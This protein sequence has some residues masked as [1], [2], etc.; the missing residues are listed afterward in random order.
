MLYFTEPT[1]CCIKTNNL[2]CF[3][4]NSLMTRPE[5]NLIENAFFP[6]TFRVSSL[7]QEKAQS[8]LKHLVGL[9]FGFLSAVNTNIYKLDIAKQQA[10][11]KKNKKLQ[12]K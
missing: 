4:F 7:D 11:Q 6:L 3:S 12:G 10:R 8:E 1:V 9:H 5:N 2:V